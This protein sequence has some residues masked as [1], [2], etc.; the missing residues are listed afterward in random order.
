MKNVKYHEFVLVF[1]S[2]L[3]VSLTLF[4]PFPAS[5]RIIIRVLLLIISIIAWRI[6]KKRDLSRAS[7]L[8]FT[9]VALSLAFLIVTPFTSNF[10][11]LE[12]N[13]SK[14]LALSKF[15]D[16][17]IIGI[18]L[19]STFLVAGYRLKSIYMTGGKLIAGLIT[20][21]IF[22]LIFGYLA[23]NNPEQK[24]APGFLEKNWL[25]IFVFVLSNGFMEELIFRG[26]FLDKLNLLFNSH[27]SIFMTSFCFAAPHLVVN[28]QPNVLL[29]AGITFILGMICGYA[30]HLTRSIIAPAL[31]HA[32][33]DLMII[34]P[35]FA[36]YG[37][38]G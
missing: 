4:S 38:A 5:I 30:M 23:L 29:F 36:S 34:V 20:G 31:I 27:L 6:F 7:L 28:Y 12:V 13:T 32:G 21:M 26:I 2:I 15:S 3:V 1:L 17:V 8:A 25:W 11:H 18:V 14:G 24:P 37:I 9:F 10:W 22:F 33:A 35:I 16:A 19:I